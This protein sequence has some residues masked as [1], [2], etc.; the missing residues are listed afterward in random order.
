MDLAIKIEFIMLELTN[1]MF[2]L[3]NMELFLFVIGFIFFCGDDKDMGAFWWFLPHIVK[4]SI[5]LLLLKSIPKTH[6]IIKNAEINPKE[7]LSIEDA[8]DVLIKSAQTGLQH[9]T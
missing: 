6:E 4:G 1:N 5:G 2:W 9:F 7:K 8:F 3:P